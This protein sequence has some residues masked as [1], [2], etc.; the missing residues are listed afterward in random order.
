[1]QGLTNVQA[2]GGN[3]AA[4]WGLFD[5]GHLNASGQQEGMGLSNTAYG[6]GAAGPRASSNNGP[7]FAAT[8][9]AAFD[10]SAMGGGERYY[11]VG[12]R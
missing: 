10:A 8:G 4:D 3:A 11:D 1:V 5:P 2:F 9:L 7:A 12:R 6:I